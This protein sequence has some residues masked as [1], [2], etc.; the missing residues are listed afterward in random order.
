MARVVVS[1]PKCLVEKPH[2]PKFGNYGRMG[3]LV[4][5]PLDESQLTKSSREFATRL[6][7]RVPCLRTNASMVLQVD[8]AGYDLLVELC[9]PK[10]KDLKMTIWVDDVGEFSVGFGPW[11]THASVW[12]AH[13]EMGGKKEDLVDLVCAI[14][15]DQ[16]VVFEDIGGA[17]NGSWGVLD[18][19]EEG[20]LAE[21]LTDKYS[22][23]RMRIR[24]WTGSRD[25]VVGLEDLSI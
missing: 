6:F 5:K 19:R 2:I 25:R 1:P 12:A 21:E 18:F 16:F 23:G 11:H 4:H 7:Q 9:S 3:E 14:L 15:H 13:T 17:Y 22:P 24:S 8:S 20:A 10:D